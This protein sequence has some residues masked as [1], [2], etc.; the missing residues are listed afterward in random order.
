MTEGETRRFW[1]PSRQA[2]DGAAGKPRGM[3]VFEITLLEIV[4]E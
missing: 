1:V 3:L 2:Y 4:R